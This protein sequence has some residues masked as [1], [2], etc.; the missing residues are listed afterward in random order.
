MTIS[1]N[2]GLMKGP[3]VAL[4]LQY[5]AT[6]TNAKKTLVLFYFD[7]IRHLQT[8]ENIQGVKFKIEDGKLP[9]IDARRRRTFK[10][11]FVH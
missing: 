7:I 11:F 3:A 9:L 10:E 2:K 4:E 5:I 8:R 6:L 1:F